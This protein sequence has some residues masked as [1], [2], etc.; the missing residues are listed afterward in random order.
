MPFEL[1]VTHSLLPG[2]RLAHL[3]FPETNKNEVRSLI[4]P[5]LHLRVQVNT[6]ESADWNFGRPK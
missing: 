3:L 5:N 4:D 6:V 1:S 2:K